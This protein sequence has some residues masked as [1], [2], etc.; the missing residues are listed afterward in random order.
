MKGSN[1]EPKHSALN[2]T[3]VLSLYQSLKGTNKTKLFFAA[4]DKRL[5][6]LIDYLGHENLREISSKD[7][8]WFRDYL[9]DRG[10][11]SSSI[12]RIFS[13]VRA[14]INLSIKEHGVNWSNVFT[15][16]YIPDDSRST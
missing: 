9:F 13:T 15:G 12:K 3:N 5:R 11:S 1:H 16:T 8:G 4:F 2:L 7:A 6:Y 10:I 14:V